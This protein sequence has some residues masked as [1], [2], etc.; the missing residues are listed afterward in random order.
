V[1]AGFSQDQID[2][3]M[4][5]CSHEPLGSEAYRQGQALLKEI[6]RERARAIGMKQAAPEEKRWSL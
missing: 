6:A 3:A 1:N 5:A 4:R 2:E